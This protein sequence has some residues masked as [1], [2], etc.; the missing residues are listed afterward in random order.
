MIQDDQPLEKRSIEVDA[1][2]DKRL[3]AQD[4]EPTLSGSVC[5]VNR[6]KAC[7]K[8]RPVIQLRKTL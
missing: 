6:I 2:G 1:A 8:D 3:P 4:R 5:L 7:L